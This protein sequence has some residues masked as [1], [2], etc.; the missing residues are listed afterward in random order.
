MFAGGIDG[1]ELPDHFRLADVFVMPS[2][3]EGFG[4]VFL[5]ALASG[6]EVISGNRDGSVDPLADGAL[7]ATVDPDNREELVAALCNSLSNPRARV[8]CAGRFDVRAFSEHLQA[9]V[10]WRSA[11]FASNGR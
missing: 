5:E 9:L 4:I 3:A 7:G 1:E 11:A 6:L 2:T 10:G 8:D